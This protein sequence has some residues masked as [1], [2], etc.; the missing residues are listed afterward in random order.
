[1]IIIWSLTSSSSTESTTSIASRRLSH[2][3]R[4]T[5]SSEEAR[6]VCVPASSEA[7]SKG[8]GKSIIVGDGLSRKGSK[9]KSWCIEV[10]VAIRTGTA[11]YVT[12]PEFAM[13]KVA[14][15]EVGGEEGRRAAL[16]GLTFLLYINEDLLFSFPF[17]SFILQKEKKNSK[18][19]VAVRIDFDSWNE[20]W[21]PAVTSTNWNSTRFGWR[22]GQHTYPK[23][24]EKRGSAK[25]AA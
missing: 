12:S 4:R 15:L 18:L 17:L 25:H 24:R 9:G 22:L 3:R 11:K 10:G 5:D 6:L 7:A 1:M 20:R 21:R 2:W 23:K 8:G 13:F 14:R 19:P 16:E